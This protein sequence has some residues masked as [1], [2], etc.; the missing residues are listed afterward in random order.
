MELTLMMGYNYE[1][2]SVFMLDY[3]TIITRDN[4]QPC[5]TQLKPKKKKPPNQHEIP[6]QSPPRHGTFGNYTI[7]TMKPEIAISD[8]VSH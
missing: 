8:Q 6:K 3:Q 1:M 5:L 2:P 4:L 7:Y